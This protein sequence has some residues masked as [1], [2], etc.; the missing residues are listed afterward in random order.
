MRLVLYSIYL[1]V[2]LPKRIK[3]KVKRTMSFYNIKVVSV[4]RMT[5]RIVLASK[6]FHF[7]KIF[8]NSHFMV[9]HNVYFCTLNL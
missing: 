9:M 1:T 2:Y 4:G 3:V 5:D 8:S 7:H 6:D